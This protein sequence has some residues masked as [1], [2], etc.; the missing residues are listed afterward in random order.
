MKTLY[1]C[2][3]FLLLSCTFNNT[4][5]IQCTEEAR[6][7]LNIT[8][9]NA[10]TNQVLGNGIT[11]TAKDGN[12]TETLEFFDVNNPVFS[13]A[14]E[15]AGTYIITVSGVGYII[16]VSES[17]TVTADECHVIPQQLQVSL[18]PE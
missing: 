7:A 9:K 10:V 8:V 11:V 4:N 2:S 5:E 15:R 14:W 17:I 13:G 6:A 18:Q 12:Y 1:L 3:I 16:F